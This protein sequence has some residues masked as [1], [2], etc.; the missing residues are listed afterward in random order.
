ML[1]ARVIRHHSVN[2][3]WTMSN[4]DLVY[5]LQLLFITMLVRCDVCHRLGLCSVWVVMYV[6]RFAAAFCDNSYIR[7]Q[8]QR[9]NTINQQES[10][11]KT[12]YTQTQKHPL[13]TKETH[14]EQTHTTQINNNKQNQQTTNPVSAAMGAAFVNDMILSNLCHCI[15]LPTLLA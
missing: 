11:K 7:W 10:Q 6:Q 4:T 2:S 3:D 13:K 15:A 1:N 8:A 12:S 14:H 9:E 5:F